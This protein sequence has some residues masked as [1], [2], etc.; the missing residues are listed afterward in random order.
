MTGP[1]RIDL[2][3]VVWPEGDK[4]RN[5]GVFRAHERF[6]WHSAVANELRRLRNVRSAEYPEGFAAY[7]V[8]G[9]AGNLKMNLYDV[10]SYCRQ[11]ISWGELVK[12]APLWDYEPDH[13]VALA[14]GEP[15]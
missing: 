9:I 3:P 2:T 11:M 8:E 1:P 15:T 7:S 13:W 14:P 12:A 10:A 4:Y 6:W 5:L